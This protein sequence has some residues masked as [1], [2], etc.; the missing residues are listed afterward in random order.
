MKQSARGR[1]LRLY[2]AAKFLSCRTYAVILAICFVL[3]T[4]PAP[5][6]QGMAV[7]SQVLAMDTVSPPQPG[8]TVS[9]SPEAQ[10][11]SKQ[12][13]ANPYDETVPDARG[14]V[15]AE[16]SGVTTPSSPSHDIYDLRTCIKMADR[17]HPDLGPAKARLLE[18]GAMI[19]EARA[20]LFP[21]VKFNGGYRYLVDTP[22]FDDYE[23]GGANQGFDFQWSGHNIW[24][25]DLKIEWP[26]FTWNRVQ[27]SQKGAEFEL[28]ARKKEYLRTREQAINDAIMAY[29]TIAS[30][31]EAKKYLDITMH[32]LSLFREVAKKD[33]EKGMSNAQEKDVMQISI[34]LDKMSAWKGTIDKWAGQAK[35]A[36]AIAIG[37]PGRRL[38]I[39]DDS[40][41]YRP[42]KIKFSACLNTANSYRADLK[43]MDSRIKEAEL[44]ASVERKANW[45]VLS[46]VGSGYLQNDNFEPSHDTNA[47]VGITLSGTLFD[48]FKSSA[49]EE[50]ATARMQELK[51]AKYRLRQQIRQEVKEAYLKVKEAYL[52]LCAYRDARER[53]MQKLRLVRQGYPVKVTDVDDVR[54]TQ[55]ERRWRD[56][57]YIFA[58]LS[59]IKALAELNYA[60]GAS[61]YDFKGNYTGTGNQK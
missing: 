33:Q 43:A 53:T 17:A 36:L 45:P 24:R 58:K 32:E 37:R 26:V 39:R 42:I 1:E 31:S 51:A 13:P 4:G 46:I 3:F 60:C 38:Q 11:V 29:W 25:G 28:D 14:S 48:G 19:R 21:V 2:A 9:A 57:E 61:V 35:Q 16:P 27:D 44:Q 6:I 18:A 12:I 23:P 5:G 41:A 30:A 47:M 8:E 15:E 50:R 55:V 10:S 52:S 49:R 54:E 40:V 34:D 22:G 56:A 20:G 7:T 59:M